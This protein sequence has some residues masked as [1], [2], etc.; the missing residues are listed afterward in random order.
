MKKTNE[1]TPLTISMP[2]DLINLVEILAATH[3][4]PQSAVY[5]VAVVVL[6]DRIGYL[7]DAEASVTPFAE[8]Y[9]KVFTSNTTL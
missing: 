5:R 8:L 9:D 6:L 1:T 2:N 4:V 7:K 3:D